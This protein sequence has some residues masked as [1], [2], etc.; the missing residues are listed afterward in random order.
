MESTIHVLWVRCIS[1]YERSHYLLYVL[2][3]F[4]LFLWEVVTGVLEIP[5]DAPQYDALLHQ[6]SCAKSYEEWLPIASTLDDLDGFQQWRTNERSAYF[7]F[8]GVMRTIEELLELRSTGNTETLLEGLHKRVHRSLCGISHHRLY[9]YRTGTKTVIHSYTSLVCFLLGR[10]GE[11]ARIDQRLLPR[12]REVLSEM[13]HVY[14][15]TALL[16]QGGVLAASAHLGVA[17]TL[18][19]AGLLPPVIYGSGSGALVAT[20][21]CCSTDLPA[22]FSRSYKDDA[23]A[24]IGGGG[25]G[26]APLSCRKRRCRLLHSGEVVDPAALTDFLQRTVGDVT[27]AEAYAQ[28]GRVLNILY[29]SAPSPLLQACGHYMVDHQLLNYLTA[30]DVVIRSA[31]RCAMCAVVT[32]PPSSTSSPEKADAVAPRGLLARTRQT[33]SIV[34]YDPPV[35]RQSYPNPCGKLTGDGARD[36]VQRMRGLF[37][38]RFSIVSDVSLRG[39]LW[40]Q[41]YLHSSSS[42]FSRQRLCMWAWLRYSC[43]LCCLGVAHLV[44]RVIALLGYDTVAGPSHTSMRAMLQQDESENVQIYPIA[45]LWSYF[46]LWCTSNVENMAALEMDAQR[47]VWP[48][49]EQLRMS[50]SVEQVLAATLKRLPR[51]E[52]E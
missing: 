43:A 23:S 25:S 18:Y 49:L 46:R 20:L 47:E 7:S 26:S 13:H 12:T 4:G 11:A 5:T 21:V 40:R 32:S 16:L 17:K 29:T 3:T 38:V 31:V 41:L 8:E 52:E 34:M 24:L 22:L 27:F 30:P 28:T 15:S 50:M 48:R 6:A 44:L 1:L 37:S 35:V 14:G 42:P 51:N 2:Y 45:G 39:Y 33:G 36:P 19:K 10:A 9:A